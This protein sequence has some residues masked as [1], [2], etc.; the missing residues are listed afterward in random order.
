M[1]TCIFWGPNFVSNSSRTTEI[2]HVFL[3]PKGG[4]HMS[5][6]WRGRPLL[7]DGIE[8][9][10]DGSDGLPLGVV[11]LGFIFYLFLELVVVNNLEESDEKLLTKEESFLVMRSLTLLLK[12]LS[13]FV[14]LRSR[15]PWASSGSS[16]MTR[17]K[18]GDEDD[19]HRNS[20]ESDPCI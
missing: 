15:S 14:L 17:E 10:V 11:L 7:E 1:P 5:E 8:L 3:P 13:S 9:G 2:E 19:F 18:M 4:T 6:A 20:G 16:I 12:M